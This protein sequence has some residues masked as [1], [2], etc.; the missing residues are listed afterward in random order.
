MY[1]RARGNLFPLCVWKFMVLLPDQTPRG[2]GPRG[3][4]GEAVLGV[5]GV[6]SSPTSNVIDLCEKPGSIK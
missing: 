3:C 1:F 2:A 4:G 5:G 6:I